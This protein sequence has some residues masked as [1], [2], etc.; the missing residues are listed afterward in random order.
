[1]I[2]IVLA[3]RAVICLKT[4]ERRVWLEETP[5]AVRELQDK[6]SLSLETPFDYNQ[7]SSRGCN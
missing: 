4:P 2:L 5:N 1:M 3:K 6:W 7:H